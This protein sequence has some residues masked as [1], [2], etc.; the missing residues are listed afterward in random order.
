MNDDDYHFQTSWYW[1][2]YSD[3]TLWNEYDEVIMM[4][5]RIME[6][7]LMELILLFGLIGGVEVVTLM[8]I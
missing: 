6:I 7:V 3:D 8:I 2:G 1:H 5:L 4:T